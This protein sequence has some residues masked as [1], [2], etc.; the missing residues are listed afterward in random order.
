MPAREQ[1]T[2]SDAHQKF[3]TNVLEFYEVGDQH[4]RPWARLEANRLLCGH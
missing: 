1:G 2:Q 3:T 4:C